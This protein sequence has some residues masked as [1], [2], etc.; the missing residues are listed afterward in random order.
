MPVTATVTALRLRLHSV[1]ARAV[2]V[3]CL[4]PALFGSVFGS[5]FAVV[6]GQKTALSPATVLVANRV[7]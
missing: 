1:T 7:F 5:G 2:G 3:K 6:I 4:A